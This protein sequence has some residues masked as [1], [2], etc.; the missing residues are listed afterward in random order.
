[1][2]RSAAKPRSS[3][4]CFAS[5]GEP[6]G[7]GPSLMIRLRK[8]PL[9]GPPSAFCPAARRQA[10]AAVVIAARA[11][12]KVRDAARRVH[13]ARRLAAIDR[14]AAELAAGRVVATAAVARGRPGS[15]QIPAVR[16]VAARRSGSGPAAAASPAVARPVAAVLAGFAIRRAA[17]DRVEPAVALVPAGRAGL[18][19]WARRVAAGPDGSA[20]LAAAVVRGGSVRASRSGGHRAGRAGRFA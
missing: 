10:P 1:M 19:G 3:G 4:R 20:I 11:G 14:V 2:V 13:R 12:R 6:R 16:T 18:G 15:S 8:T 9:N 5:P 17:A 7:H